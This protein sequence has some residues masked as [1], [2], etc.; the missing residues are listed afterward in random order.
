MDPEDGNDLND[1]LEDDS[2]QDGDAGSDNSA[3]PS[4]AAGSADNSSQRIND[5]MGKWQGEQA[6]NA[7]LQREL[8]ALRAGSAAEPQSGSAGGSDQSGNEFMDFAR[9][10]ARRRIFEQDPSLAAAG[11]DSSSIAGST[12]EEMKASFKAQQTLVQGIESRARAN[13]LKQHGLDPE[14]VAGGHEPVEKIEQ[15]SDEDFAK[16]LTQRDQAR[17]R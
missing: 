9:E 6:R 14:V 1:G 13:V 8:E 4:S 10:D 15:M 5:L 16:F 3:P 2:A 7:K 11:L 17:Y 12:L